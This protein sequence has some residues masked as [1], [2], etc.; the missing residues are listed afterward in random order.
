MIIRKSSLPEQQHLVGA[1]LDVE[2][3]HRKITTRVI[4]Y[5]TD[6]GS[7]ILSLRTQEHPHYGQRYTF[8]WYPN[9][10]GDFVAMVRRVEEEP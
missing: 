1:A 3:E 7:N 10:D 5:E 6:M 9:K 2:S 8:L 4:A